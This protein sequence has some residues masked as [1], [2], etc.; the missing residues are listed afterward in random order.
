M[1]GTRSFAIVVAMAALAGSAACD[2]SDRTDRTD[3]TTATSPQTP[4]YQTDEARTDSGITT[5]VQSRYYSQASVRGRDIDVIT[6]NGVVTLRGTV[7]DDASRQQAENIARQVEGVN[8][9]DNQ[10]RVETADAR[11]AEPGRTAD[12][13]P[14]GRDGDRADRDDGRVNAGWLTTRIQ[15]QYFTT[16]DVRARN[17]DV[18]SN[19]DGVVSLRG[20][21]EN[22]EERRRAIEI[23]QSTD[24]TT[25]VEDHLRITGAVATTGRTED[26]PRDREKEARTTQPDGWVT[27]KIQAKYFTDGA[28]RGRDI[29]VDTNNGVVTLRG[30]V[31]SEAERRQAIALARNTDGVRDVQDQLNLEPALGDGRADRPDTERDAPAT[32]GAT[33]RNVGDRTAATDRNVGDRTAATGRDAGDRMADGW[34]TTKVQAS[35]FLNTDIRGRDINVNTSNGVVTLNGTVQTDAERSEAEQIARE[36]DGVSRVVNNLKVGGPR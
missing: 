31:R 6:S 25:R 23:A 13:G 34:I 32:T 4:G 9:V 33:D 17:I 36:I 12:A 35:Y 10:L 14:A 22:E 2:R 27:T 5:A 7:P 15:A 19:S 8:R 11:M 24:G 28:V 1:G 30:A 20:E 18:T 26:T 16:T 29:N 3:P 21:V